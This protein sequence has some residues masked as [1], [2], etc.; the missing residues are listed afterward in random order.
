MTLGI[1]T[2]FWI[3]NYYTRCER[4][5]IDLMQLSYVEL[6]HFLCGIQWYL[7]VW[8]FWMSLAMSFLREICCGKSVRFA[9]T[10]LQE[11]YMSFLFETCTDV[12]VWDF[13]ILF[14]EINMYCVLHVLWDFATFFFEW[15]LCHFCVRHMLISL[16]EVLKDI[17]MTS[18]CKFKMLEM[19]ILCLRYKRWSYNFKG[20]AN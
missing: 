4:T 2:T 19:R 10:F 6:V 17:W 14:C 7:W 20:E 13:I 3:H 18:L 8:H 12:T 15:H 5:Y 1:S 16:C 9:I 11:I